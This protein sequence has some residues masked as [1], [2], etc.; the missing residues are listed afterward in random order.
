[1]N[2]KIYFPFSNITGQDKAKLALILALVNEKI[3]GVILFGATGTG[4][5]TL[6]RS[7]SEIASVELI[8]IPLNITDDM[9][10][11]GIDIETTIKAGSK[12]LSKSLLERA[13]HNIIYIDDINLLRTETVR[14]LQGS[15]AG[16]NINNY[17]Y[18]VLA[19]ANQQ[20]GDLNLNIL[21]KFG[22]SVSLNDIFTE[23]ER[24]EIIKNNL[25]F[26]DDP[27]KFR[28]VAQ[29]ELE[30][31][32]Q[33]I[34]CGKNILPKVE[35]SSQ[36]LELIAVY[37]HKANCC[38]HRAEIYMVEASKAFAA[39]Q[40][41]TYV[42]PSDIEVVAELVLAHRVRQE[43][44]NDDNSKNNDNNDNND[45]NEQSPPDEEAEQPSAP[46]DNDL[47]EPTEEI[48][49]KEQS[50]EDDN[51]QGDNAENNKDNSDSQ[52]S[53]Q[54]AIA[55]ENIA[56][57]DKSFEGISIKVEELLQQKQTKSGVGKRSYTKTALKQGRY[58]R[59]CFKDNVNDLAFDA[60]IRAAAPYQKIRK[61]ER[62]LFVIDKSDLRQKIREKRIGKTFI[63][64]VDASGSMGVKMRMKA[65]KGAI[66][67]LLNDVYQ[68]RDQVGL[69]AFRRETAEVVLP[70]TRSVDLAQKVLENLPTGG[71]TPLVE[72][73]SKTYDLIKKIQLNR[74]ELEP[75]VVLITDGRAN[76][77]KNNQ[78]F[79]N[80]LEGAEKL[81]Q[82]SI[83]S[84]VID[85]ENDYIKF[86]FAKSIA[87]AMSA[88]Y[89]HFQ[90][91]SQQNIL[92]IIKNQA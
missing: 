39:L 29:G 73:L 4:K 32:K 59:A 6:L 55:Q 83:K 56:D 20:E 18:T 58:V 49:S 40:Q 68:K 54:E 23:E 86:G 1:M 15:S 60:T 30:K 36:I 51:D 45:N 5:S 41:R 65:V 44:S 46:E 47:D 90:Q 82:L 16:D 42:L 52:G 89:Y 19:G 76:N 64:V 38:G 9:L 7:L 70:V 24:T 63:F 37:C 85:T 14:I 22:L 25:K 27:Q 2:N 31:I 91:L 48:E 50:S 66:F 28:A 8:N 43:Q 21:D 3:S 78:N 88:N 10:L 53:G 11:G 72:G 81:G 92:H 75:I 13:K 87:S 12:V 61:S 62:T 69:I 35:I 79:T 71:K 26:E 84:V 77:H 33:E 34:V 80:V 57:I 17:G 67:S 74:S